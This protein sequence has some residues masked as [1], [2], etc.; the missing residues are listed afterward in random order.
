MN[1]SLIVECK[2]EKYD[3]E[4]WIWSSTDYK[5]SNTKKYAGHLCPISQQIII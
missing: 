5:E 1:R 2:K 4:E 3:L